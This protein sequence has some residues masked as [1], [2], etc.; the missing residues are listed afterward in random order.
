MVQ[1]QHVYTAILVCCAAL[2]AF[3]QIMAHWSRRAW[4]PFELTAADF[5]SF[6]MESADWRVERKPPGDDPLQPNILVLHM[7]ASR[8]DPSSA[9]PVPVLVRLVHGYNMCDC[10]RI[11]GYTVELLADTRKPGA[12]GRQL[13]RLT[14]GAGDV[15]VWVTRMLRAGDLA[16][17]DVDVRSMAFPRVGTPDDPRWMPE[18]LTLKSLRHPVRNLRWYFRAKWNNARADWLTFLGLKRPAWASDEMLT[19]VAASSVAS[20][21]ADDERAAA[22]RVLA[23]QDSVHRELKRWKAG[24]NDAEG[25]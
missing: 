16:G 8:E 18:G 13:W 1:R 7:L 9:G 15:S 5:E 12:P 10:M 3:W 6:R 23:A 25:R 11:K 19:L 17:T 20:G 24:K 2:M 22:Q 21:G 4:E 14:S